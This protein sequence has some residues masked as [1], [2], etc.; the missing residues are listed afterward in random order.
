VAAIR[1]LWLTLWH[2]K[3]RVVV[4]VVV[5][6]LLVEV[7]TGYTLPSRSKHILGP[8]NTM[9]YIVLQPGPIATHVV[10]VFGWLVGWLG[11]WSRR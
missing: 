7:S 2:V 9:Q 5:V 10:A 1:P 3:R 4:V 8:G 6:G 11:E